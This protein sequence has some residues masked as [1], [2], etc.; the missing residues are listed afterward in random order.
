MFRRYP[1]WVFAKN[2]TAASNRSLMTGGREGSGRE[3]RFGVESE[4]WL[5]F[6]GWHHSPCWHGPWGQ[7][8]RVYRVPRMPFTPINRMVGASGSLVRVTIFPPKPAQPPP[9][10]RTRFSTTDEAQRWRG[11]R[12]RPRG[13][14]TG[15][16]TLDRISDCILPQQPCREVGVTGAAR[17]AIPATHAAADQRTS[18]RVVDLTTRMT[19]AVGAVLSPPM[20]MVT[21]RRTTADRARSTCTKP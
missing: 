18:V 1:G 20:T 4:C 15:T 11:V 2:K 9:H 14:S 13:Y 5:G 10:E 12:P 3:Q 16:S 17:P 7:V 19:Y 21:A 6:R 8:G